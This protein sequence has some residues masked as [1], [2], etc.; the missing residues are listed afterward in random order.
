MPYSDFKTIEDIKKKFNVKI[1]SGESLFT[2]TEETHPSHLLTEILQ[3]NI[4]LA[5]NINTEKAR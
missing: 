2:K 1:I 3:D 5:L 4:S